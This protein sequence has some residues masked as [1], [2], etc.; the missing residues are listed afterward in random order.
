MLCLIAL[1]SSFTSTEVFGQMNSWTSVT[2]GNW[3]QP[4]NWSLGLLPNSSQSVM[5][6]NAGFKDVFFLRCDSLEQAQKE[7]EKEYRR[8]FNLSDISLLETD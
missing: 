5:I 8:L 6:T 4:S 2:S 3:D 1:V 7:C